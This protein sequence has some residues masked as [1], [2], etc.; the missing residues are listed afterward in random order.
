MPRSTE[1]Y[2]C[3]DNKLPYSKEVKHQRLGLALYVLQANVTIPAS[4][5]FSTRDLQEAEAINSP[6]SAKG[7]VF[8]A[9]RPC[10]LMVSLTQE[11]HVLAEVANPQTFLKL[12]S[13]T[14][15]K[16]SGAVSTALSQHSR[17]R[18]MINQKPF[19]NG[20][21]V[22]ADSMQN[23]NHSVSVLDLEAGESFT[24]EFN[25]YGVD[26]ADSSIE[27]VERSTVQITELPRYSPFTVRID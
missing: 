22:K 3:P 11:I 12:Y 21:A 26:S 8:T 9:V 1:G 10:R 27:G 5:P 16:P 24:A 18:E 7:S 15:L 23:A 6:V 13:L 2:T 25:V 17:S 4:S 19:E 14:R 20:G